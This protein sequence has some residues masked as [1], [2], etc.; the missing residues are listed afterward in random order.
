MFWYVKDSKDEK[1]LLTIE[2]L[3]KYNF[4]K[5]KKEF[6]IR[7]K[8]LKEEIKHIVINPTFKCNLDCWYCYSREYHHKNYKEISLN[9]IKQIILF[10]SNHRKEMNSSKPLAIS[11][12]FTSEITLNFSLFREV[13]KFIDQIKKEY[14]FGF[15]LFPASTNLMSV[16]DEFVDFINNYGYINVSL[17]LENK[18]Q[19]ETVLKNISRFEST[20]VKHCIIPL[21]SEMNDLFSIYASFMKS[22]DY[23]SMRPVRITSNSKIPWT[24]KS[25]S[26]FKHE[27]AKLFENLLSLDEE[28]LLNF[29]YRLGSSDYLARFLDRIISRKKYYSRCLAGK[30]E[31]AIS[32]DMNFY[33]CSGLIGN[34]K[35]KIGSIYEGLSLKSTNDLGKSNNMNNSECKKCPIRFYCGGLCL[36]WFEKQ[37][38]ITG[39]QTNSIECEINIHYF[40]L[41]SYF[42]YNISRNNSKILDLIARKKEIDNRLSYPLDFSDFSLFFQSRLN[43]CEIV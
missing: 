24:E 9:D 37:Q 28:D 6:E 35:Y 40:K 20:V 12:F 17:D 1:L 14:S 23:V 4:F 16:S 27:L 36:D 42:I 39:K 32:P 8:E 3:K 22:F 11:M 43:S 7:N 25:I 38:P 13:E 10:F 21:N 31:I 5:Q 2:Q 41:G 30:N 26:D 33:L 34:E 29:L 18:E 15:F 19:I